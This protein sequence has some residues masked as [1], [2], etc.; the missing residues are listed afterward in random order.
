MTQE[1]H[2]S[3]EFAWCMYPIEYRQRALDYCVKKW[4]TRA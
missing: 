1:E 4:N 3:A 2:G